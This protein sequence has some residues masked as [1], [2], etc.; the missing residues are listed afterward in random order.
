MRAKNFV[1]VGRTPHGSHAAQNPEYTHLSKT[2]M[3]FLILVS[4]SPLQ[5]A[6]KGVAE[7]DKNIEK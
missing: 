3:Y 5:I 1:F 2:K 4:S 7:A 6:I